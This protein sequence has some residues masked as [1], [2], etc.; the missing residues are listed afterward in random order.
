[1]RWTSLPRKIERSRTMR[2]ATPAKNRR[3]RPGGRVSRLRAARLA[4][5]TGRD[6]GAP[7]PREPIDARQIRKR[8]PWCERR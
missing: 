2:K 1:V 8:Q 5:R 3:A 4:T 7:T 6:A